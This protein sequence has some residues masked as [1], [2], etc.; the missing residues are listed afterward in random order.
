MPVRFDPFPVSPL[1]P[2]FLSVRCWA[3][4]AQSLL[5]TLTMQAQTTSRRLCALYPNVYCEGHSGRAWEG[6]MERTS[7]MPRKWRLPRCWLRFLYSRRSNSATSSHSS[8]R[9][10]DACTA[11]CCAQSLTCKIAAAPGSH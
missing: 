4:E 7:S 10:S 3:L 9:S 2:Q 11:S 8:G 1:V 5:I 6:A